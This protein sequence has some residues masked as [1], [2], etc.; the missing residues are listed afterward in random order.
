MQ[1]NFDNIKKSLTENLNNMLLKL[2]SVKVIASD[3]FTLSY[4]DLHNKDR[5]N[6][7]LTKINNLDSSDPSKKHLYRI[8]LVDHSVLDYDEINKA[9]TNVKKTE[10][11]ISTSRL[12]NT[13]QCQ[14]LYVGSSSTKLKARI[15]NHLGYGS[16]KTYA[17]HLKYWFPDIDNLI[18][19][20]IIKITETDMETLLN[21]EELYWENNKPLFGKKS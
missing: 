18:K 14:S 12:L 13:Q 4:L 9:M 8:S 19:I 10:P 1:S 5:V 20:E 2:K 21:F 3:S 17:L 7:I 11:L 6:D 15:R 16:V